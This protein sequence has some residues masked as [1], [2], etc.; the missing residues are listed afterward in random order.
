LR[1]RTIEVEQ[2]ATEI[3]ATQMIVYGGIV[4]VTTDPQNL[5]LVQI[6]TYPVSTARSSELGQL[7]QS[8]P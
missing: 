7:I 1:P 6:L 3:I 4:D 5:E 2:Y 8:D